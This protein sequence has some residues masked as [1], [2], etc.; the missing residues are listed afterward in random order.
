[1]EVIPWLETL[2]GTALSTALRESQWLYPAVETAHLLGLATLVGSAAAFDLRLLGVSRHLP[3]TAT[4]RHLLRC[5]W[6]GFATA[7]ASGA[8]LFAAEPVDTAANPAFR[9][10][11]VLL[12]VAGLNAARFHVGP[13][14]TVGGWD[15]GVPAPR[16]ARIA[17]AVSLAAWAGVVAAGRLIAYV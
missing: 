2:R 14:R 10:K 8:L 12:A 3:V 16:S 4:A 15:R 6:G 17:A 7:A 1:V 13:F 9:V 11:L 5:A